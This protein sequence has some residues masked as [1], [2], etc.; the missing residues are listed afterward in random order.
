MDTGPDPDPT[1]FLYVS[2][3]QK[4]QDQSK[5]YDPE[6]SCWVPD[7]KEGFVEGEIQATKGDLITVCVGEEKKEWKKDMVHLV[8]PPELEKCEDMS[9]LTELNGPSLFHNVKS[10][11]LNQLFYT[12]A[13]PSCVVINP[14]KRY[15]IYTKRVAKIYQGKKRNEVPP[16]LFGVA[17]NA[18]TAMLQGEYFSCWYSDYDGVRN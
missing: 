17:E 13:G 2:D 14:C 6:K 4:E 3:Q 10:R 12:Y 7:E 9:D 1:G 11:Y 16:H 18:Y 8:N 15:P 5:P